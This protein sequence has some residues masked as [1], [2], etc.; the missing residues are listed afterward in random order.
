MR[1]FR[2]AAGVNAAGTCSL[3]LVHRGA[4]LASGGD[5]E[6]VQLQYCCTCTLTCKLKGLD[7]SDDVILTSCVVREQ[8]HSMGAMAMATMATRPGVMIAWL[9]ICLC[10]CSSPVTVA[11]AAAAPLD[12]PLLFGSGYI[13]PAWKGLTGDAATKWEGASL[14][15][16]VGMGATLTG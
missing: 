16:L 13:Y 14:D 1:T 8:F 2:N 6:T 10:D 11:A 4:P 7:R 12:R 15:A 5:V 9:C 3:A